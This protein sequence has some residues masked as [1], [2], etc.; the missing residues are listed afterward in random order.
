MG[1]DSSF[2][3][4]LFKGDRQPLVFLT[5]GVTVGDEKGWQKFLEEVDEAQG[6]GREGKTGLRIVTIFFLSYGQ[7]RK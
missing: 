5:E 6:K 3:F 7:D 2:H 1:F 4:R